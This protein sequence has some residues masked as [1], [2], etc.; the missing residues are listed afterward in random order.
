MS[1]KNIWTIVLS[2]RFRM[3]RSFSAWVFRGIFTRVMGFP[4]D[5]YSGHKIWRWLFRG[6]FTWISRISGWVPDGVFA[7]NALDL[8]EVFSLF[9]LLSFLCRIP[10]ITP[11]LC[12]KWC[13]YLWWTEH[14]SFVT[15]W[16]MLTAHRKVARLF[17]CSYL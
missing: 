6:I 7:R 4:R 14:K 10:K 8:V 15:W 13:G 17:S 1:L 5:F 11:Q 2:P 16:L 12:D 3:F 9:L